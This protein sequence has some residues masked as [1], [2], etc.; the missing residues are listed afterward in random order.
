M[1]PWRLVCICQLLFRD[2]DGRINCS[3]TLAKLSASGSCLSTSFEKSFSGFNIPSD[4]VTRLE[5]FVFL[6]LFPLFW[7]YCFMQ[8]RSCDNKTVGSRRSNVEWFAER[9]ALWWCSDD[10]SS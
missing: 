2:Q 7:V 8:A 3:G 5:G 4:M 6:Y 1:A 9:C 10:V